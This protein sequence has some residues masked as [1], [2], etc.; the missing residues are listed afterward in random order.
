MVFSNFAALTCLDYQQFLECTHKD[1]GISN[2]TP[3]DYLKQGDLN[4]SLRLLQEQVKKQPANSEYRIFLFQ[5]L[6]IM[7]QWERALTQLR[8]VK[9]LDDKA[10][11]LAQMYQQIIICE[12]FREQVFSGSKKPLIVGEPNKWIALLIQALK[13]ATEEKYV[14][15]LELRSQAFEEA[16]KIAGTINDDAFVWLADSDV[17]IGPVIEAFINGRYIWTT[18]EN[19]SDIIIE[20]PA[21]L[22]DLVWLPAHFTW[23]N[24]GENYGLLPTRYPYSY[25]SDPLLALSRKTIWQE[26]SNDLSIGYG[27]KMWITDIADY[28]MMETW[29]IKIHSV[30][31]NDER[32]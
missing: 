29:I 22:R 7:G 19:L 27:Q 24:G 25:Q 28:P 9:E 18:L 2:M 5:L 16:P 3:E 14:A 23:K 11:A 21:D 26:Y 15:S 4:E 13:L 10:I 32:E 1:F 30:S 17:R 20:K 12:Q 8:V 31:E 6:S